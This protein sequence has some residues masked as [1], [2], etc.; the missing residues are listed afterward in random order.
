MRVL[1]C[2]G[3]DFDER[4]YLYRV[5]DD[6]HPRPTLII[7]G[8]AHGADWLAGEWAVERDIPVREFV[9]DWRTHGKAAGPMR[10]AK[11]LADGK[12]D[13]VIAFKGGAGTANMKALARKSRIEVREV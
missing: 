10:N 11:M 5:L 8:N 7:H 1:V 3:R 6:L 4:V 9:A 13:L 12:P 2:G